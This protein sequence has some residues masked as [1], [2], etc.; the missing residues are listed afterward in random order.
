ML[1][2]DSPRSTRRSKAT[3]D[4]KHVLRGHFVEKHGHAALHKLHDEESSPPNRESTSHRRAGSS[5]LR[6]AR[7]DRPADLDRLAPTAWVALAACPVPGAASRLICN[8]SITGDFTGVQP[9][10]SRLNPRE[11]RVSPVDQPMTL[12]HIHPTS[13]AEILSIC[14]V[15][16]RLLQFRTAEPH[17]R[18]RLA[19]RGATKRCLA[20]ALQTA[21]VATYQPE[22]GRWRL[23]GGVDSEGDALALIVEL[24]EG[25][26]IV[27]LF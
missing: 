16:G 12:R 13:P 10:R 7:R 26:L 22:N 8:Q 18:K 2:S 5:G 24:R 1:S 20:R 17:A 27:T 4:R 6:G 9:D 19:E 21:T 25:V 11:S 3:R 23:D 14:S 15:A